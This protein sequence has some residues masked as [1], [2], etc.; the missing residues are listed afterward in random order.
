MKQPRRICL[1]LCDCYK[2]GK[3]SE[4]MQ[5]IIYPNGNI[6]VG[7]DAFRLLDKVDYPSYQLF[8]YPKLS[9]F[10]EE[11]ELLGKSPTDHSKEALQACFR[12]YWVKNKHHLQGG[13]KIS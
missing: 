5:A 4:Q 7:Y 9:V 2:K 6:T 1:Y 8:Y 13:K 10:M 12:K 3:R 11:F